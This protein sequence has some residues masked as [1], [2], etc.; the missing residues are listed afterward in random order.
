ML[1]PFIAT[2]GQVVLCLLIG[3]FLFILE[4][5]VPGF[6]I[7]GILGIVFLIVGI[8]LSFLRYSAV[9]GAI[10]MGVVLAVVALIAVMAYRSLQH[11]R[12]SR[13]DM[14]L[15]HS[16]VG[17]A[18]RDLSHM[19][20]KEGTCLTTLHPIG[21]ACFGEIAIDVIAENGFIAKGTRVLVQRVVGVNIYVMPIDQTQ[22]SMHS[23][24][25]CLESSMNVELE[26]KDS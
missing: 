8:V 5:F 18:I 22:I 17:R 3:V 19:A 15:N 14:I 23:P 10:I 12:L 16:S 6:S 11:G 1:A 26:L 7:V 9:V 2:H 24:M 4:V 20:G 21:T 13:S 25:N